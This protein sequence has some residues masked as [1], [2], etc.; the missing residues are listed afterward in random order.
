MEGVAA[1]EPLPFGG[2]LYFLRLSE[3]VFLSLIFFS[4]TADMPDLGKSVHPL[5]HILK[6]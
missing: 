2:T 6:L 1:G 5:E 4:L 3:R